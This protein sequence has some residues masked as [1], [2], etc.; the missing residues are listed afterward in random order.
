[1]S[2]YEK[3]EKEWKILERGMSEYQEKLKN[4]RCDKKNMGFNLDHRFK[5]HSDI[6]VHLDSWYG[7]YGDSNCS[8]I[9]RGLGDLFKQEF[10]AYLNLHRDKILKEI[11]VNLKTKAETHKAEELD[12][13]TKRIQEIK[14]E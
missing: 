4:P 11:I 8:T 10:I 9:V 1:M 14:G 2:E 6:T 3:Y 7:Y 12:K 13:L 5:A